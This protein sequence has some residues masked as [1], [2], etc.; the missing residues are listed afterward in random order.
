[1]KGFNVGARLTKRR[2]VSLAHSL[3]PYKKQVKA[4]I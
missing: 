1:M 3:N 2:L 4:I